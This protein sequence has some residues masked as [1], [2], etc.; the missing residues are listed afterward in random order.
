MI[1]K[2]EFVQ[3][4][5]RVLMILEEGFLYFAD[6]FTNCSG[7]AHHSKKLGKIMVFLN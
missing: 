3:W 6:V 4:D 5:S 7:L 2:S 1:L